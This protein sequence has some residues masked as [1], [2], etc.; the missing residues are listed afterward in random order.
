MPPSRKRKRAM[1]ILATRLADAK[2]RYR[3]RA[4]TARVGTYTRPSRVSLQRQSVYVGRGPVP[5]ETIVWMKY[6]QDFNSSASALDQVFNL[7]SIFDPDRTGTGHQ[8]LGRDQYAT[9]YNRYRVTDVKVKIV[10][11]QDGGV[12]VSPS[13]LIVVADNDPADYT[14]STTMQEQR[15]AWSTLLSYYKITLFKRRYHLASITGVTDSAYLDDRFQ[16][17]MSTSPAESIVL[18]VGTC[19]ADG[20]AGLAA[21][22]KYAVELSFKVHLFDPNTLAAS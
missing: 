2:A 3:K 17:L 1:G 22:V 6:A 9:L 4:R 15:G 21:V 5:P 14:T 19:K 11:V 8:P 7:N 13:K 20:S 18:H 16:S 12:G 10:A